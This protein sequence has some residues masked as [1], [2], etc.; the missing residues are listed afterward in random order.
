MFYRTPTFQPLE[1][2]G[3]NRSFSSTA[4]GATD[5]YDE[6]LHFIVDCELTIAEF[7][8]EEHRAES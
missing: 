3:S 2:K 4:I 6:G 5:S 1:N 7:I 8:S